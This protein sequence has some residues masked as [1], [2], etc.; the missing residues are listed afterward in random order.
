MNSDNTSNLCASQPIWYK[1][2]PGID[3][4]MTLRCF[5]K[6][7]GTK[8]LATFHSNN[9]ET[10]DFESNKIFIVNQSAFN[11]QTVFF[12]FHFEILF[13]SIET[14]NRSI[15][16]WYIP[17]RSLSRVPLCPSFNEM[18]SVKLIKMLVH[19]MNT[20]FFY[21]APWLP[22]MMTIIIHNSH[23]V[24]ISIQNFKHF[25]SVNGDMIFI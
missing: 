13:E 16:D 3:E 5:C 7:T 20:F 23:F 6:D 2:N 11:V 19:V 25:I 24:L 14:S 22:Y 12:S 15:L 18:D 8:N 9:D 4:W 21:F 10:W 1:P 17:W